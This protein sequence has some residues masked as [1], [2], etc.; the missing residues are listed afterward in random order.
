MY[1][2]RSPH[3]KDLISASYNII[4]TI[5][6]LTV[7]FILTET[8]LFHIIF[9]KNREWPPTETSCRDNHK[10]GISDVHS[11]V[12]LLWWNLLLLFYR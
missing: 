9:I 7:I 3:I 1:T 5:V 2:K 8:F 11:S 6:I 12:R 10:C 4:A